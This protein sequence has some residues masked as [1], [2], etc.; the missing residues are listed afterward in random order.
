V[1]VVISA[2][3]SIPWRRSVQSVSAESLPPLQ[4]SA[5][6]VRGVNSGGAALGPNGR[7]RRGR[8]VV[9]PDIKTSASAEGGGPAAA[10][11]RTA[12]PPR[13]DVRSARGGRP[14][15][16]PGRGLTVAGQ[17]RI[18]PDFA[19]PAPAGNMCPALRAY[20]IGWTLGACPFAQS[21]CALRWVD[22]RGC[23]RLRSRR[24]RGSP[25]LVTVHPR[26]TS[27]RAG[28]RGL[29][30]RRICPCRADASSARSGAAT[31]TP[32][33]GYSI[34]TSRGGGCARTGSATVARR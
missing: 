11:A 24:R 28:S 7:E 9:C 10:A 12:P 30:T 25:S 33:R 1:T 32:R 16:S 5:N 18:A 14:G 8:P 19:A 15:S 23:G 20:A 3:G 27:R 17:R 6:G 34:P 21:R 26:R 4:E 22:R 29:C 31:S 13:A 2:S